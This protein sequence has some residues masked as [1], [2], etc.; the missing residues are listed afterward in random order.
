MNCSRIIKSLFQ[1]RVEDNTNFK[2]WGGG[3]EAKC[4]LL[5]VY[6][7]AKSFLG[8]LLTK[9]TSSSGGGGFHGGICSYLIE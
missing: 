8:G 5:T 2:N 6:W 9:S 7:G 4:W 1:G 3:G